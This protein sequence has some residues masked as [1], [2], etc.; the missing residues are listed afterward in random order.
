MQSPWQAMLALL[1]GAV[2]MTLGLQPSS[3]RVSPDTQEQASAIPPGP[4][5]WLT[6]RH[7]TMLNIIAVERDRGLLHIAG[8]ACFDVAGG[9]VHLSDESRASSTTWTRKWVK[10]WKNGKPFVLTGKV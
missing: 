2:M 5:F 3:A 7:D 9:A 10:A 6:A 1:V 4:T 8:A